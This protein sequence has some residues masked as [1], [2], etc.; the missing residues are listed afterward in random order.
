VL[1]G[2]FFVFYAG[3]RIF[4]EQFREPDSELV[5]GG[6]LTS[7]QFLSLFMIVAGVAFLVAAKVLPGKGSRLREP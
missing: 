5:L 1:T 7:G 4:A 6:M 2:L 3:F